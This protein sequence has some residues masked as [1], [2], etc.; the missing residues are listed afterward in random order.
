MQ[1]GNSNEKGM[2]QRARKL[3]RASRNFN[4]KCTI[5][6][7]KRKKKTTKRWNLHWKP[8]SM[9][10]NIKYKEAEKLTTKMK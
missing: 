9:N 3:Q 10:I 2:P 8:K 1:N 6:P 4:A 7:Y 5:N